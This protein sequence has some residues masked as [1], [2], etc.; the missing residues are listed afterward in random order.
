M[1]RT[2]K[3]WNRL[4]RGVVQSSYHLRF[5]RPDWIKPWATWSGLIADPSLY[6]L[7]WYHELAC[8]PIIHFL[9]LRQILKTLTTWCLLAQFVLFSMMWTLAIFQTSSQF[10]QRSYFFFFTIAQVHPLTISFWTQLTKFSVITFIFNHC[11][12]KKIIRRHKI[13]CRINL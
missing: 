10:P 5:S 1:V 8:G 4:P 7:K 3:P 11:C 6:L 13:S 12:K 2:I 9:T